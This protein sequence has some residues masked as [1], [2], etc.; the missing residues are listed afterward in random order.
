[1]K[2]SASFIVEF[3]LL[4]SLIFVTV[5]LYQKDLQSVDSGYDL[6]FG[7]AT[8]ESPLYQY[9]NSLNSSFQELKS[10]IEKAQN[11][12]AGLFT[13]LANGLVAIPK[14]LFILPSAAFSAA[15]MTFILINDFTA[16]TLK[17]SPTITQIII[18]ALGIAVVIGMLEWIS[19]RGSQQA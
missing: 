5:N 15:S 6:K 13:K 1:M 17:L 18:I 7:N 12:E 10:N 3:L 16:N 9:S 14:A 8:D 2:I 4:V 11:P 19:G